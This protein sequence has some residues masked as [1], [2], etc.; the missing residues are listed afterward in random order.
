METIKNVFLYLVSFVLAL[1]TVVI[2][3]PVVAVILVFGIALISAIGSALFPFII[4]LAILGLFVG[5]IVGLCKLTCDIRM[6]LTK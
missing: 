3:L 5:T 1:A 2:G 4:I 6:Y